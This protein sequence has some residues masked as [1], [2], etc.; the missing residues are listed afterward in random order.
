[1]CL[2]LD[3]KMF[4]ILV[5]AII[6]VQLRLMGMSLVISQ[7]MGLFFSHG[8]TIEQENRQIHPIG[9]MIHC[10]LFCILYKKIILQEQT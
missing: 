6:K 10:H 2:T 1:M 7:N 5:L 9:T 4:T 3:G 8:G